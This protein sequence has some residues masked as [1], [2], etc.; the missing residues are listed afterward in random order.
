M[1]PVNLPGGRG[2]LSNK[3]RR[4]RSSISAVV[5]GFWISLIGILTHLVDWACFYFI[6][7]SFLMLIKHLFWQVCLE[8][9]NESNCDCFYFLNLLKG[10]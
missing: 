8:I 3:G 6:P 10:Y 2:R 9:E 4:E 1:Y 7:K 5:S